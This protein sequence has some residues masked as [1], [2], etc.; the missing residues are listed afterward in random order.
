M[1]KVQ[2]IRQRGSSAFVQGETDVRAEASAGGLQH[3]RRGCSAGSDNPEQTYK[4]AKMS[5][6]LRRFP[7]IPNK[8]CKEAKIHRPSAVATTGTPIKFV[9]HDWNPHEILCAILH[10]HPTSFQCLL[11]SGC[12]FHRKNLESFYEP[13]PLN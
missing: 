6:L 11:F 9:S 1:K 2:S 13:P 4:D 7:E 5:S 12:L 3:P 10:S 8:T